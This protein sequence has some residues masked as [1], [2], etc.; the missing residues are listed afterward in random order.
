[1]Q[2]ARRTQTDN[3]NLWLPQQILIRKAWNPETPGRGCKGCRLPPADGNESGPLVI[4]GKDGLFMK[5]GRHPRPHDGKPNNLLRHFSSCL[6]CF[7]LP[8]A[9]TGFRNHS[10]SFASM[11][12][13]GSNRPRA[14]RVCRPPSPGDTPDRPR[15]RPPRPRRVDG[16]R[17]V[18]PET[19]SRS[20]WPCRAA[21]EWRER[22]AC[23]R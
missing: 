9:H 21:P 1:M 18:P 14:V 16:G 4:I 22:R 2:T 10:R 13:A 17:P 19:H 15:P 23:R 7:V 3:I 8:S 20:A 12:F 6:T 11:A 5:L